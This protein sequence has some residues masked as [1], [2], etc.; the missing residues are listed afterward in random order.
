M[1]PG[2]N[3]GDFKTE[4][5]KLISA[6][7]AEGLLK[8][9]RIERAFLEIK[10]EDFLYTGSS[11]NEA[12]LDE[13]VPLGD[14][15]QTISAPH[16]VAIMLEES[17]LQTGQRVLEIGTGSGYSAC[18]V[19]SIVSDEQSAPASGSV[20]T[21]ERDERLALLARANIK[22][23]GYEK[24]VAVKIGDGTLGYPEASEQEMYD[25]IIVAAG[26]PAVPPYLEKQL[27]PG[28][29]LLVPVG[30]LPYQT[31]YRITKTGKKALQWERL[32]SCMFV[33]LV[34][35]HGHRL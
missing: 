21:I 3:H 22:K 14:T 26:A 33:P 29:I 35:E 11:K 30:N 17:N 15:G 13:P 6:L 5:M 24:T 7:K 31:L 9:P 10:R 4:K 20:I 27:K 25:R 2:Q 12:Y 18:L 8:S 1:A 23:A 28:G 19:A 32:M 16:M 34:G